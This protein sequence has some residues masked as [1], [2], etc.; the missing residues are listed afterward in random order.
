MPRFEELLVGDVCPSL[1]SG[2]ELHLNES[3]KSQIHFAVSWQLLQF[4]L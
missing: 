1:P 2:R 4:L 3:K